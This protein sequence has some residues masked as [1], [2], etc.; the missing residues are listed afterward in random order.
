LLTKVG[1]YALLRVFTLIF[2]FDE[3]ISNLFLFA[4]SSTLITG[5]VGEI[6]KR[7]I[8]RMFSYLIVCHIGFLI[9]GLG[10][11]TMVALTGAIF[12]L[13]HDVII[14]TNLF[15]V[16]GVI[17][18]IKG[19]M[20]MRKLGGMYADYPVLSLVMAVVLFS[21]VG[22]PP[23]SGFWAKIYLFEAGFDTHS[24]ILTTA[25]ILASFITLLVMARMWSEVFWKNTPEA[26]SHF[27]DYFR[28][29][30]R[31]QQSALIGPVV[32]L[33]GVSLYIGF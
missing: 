2:I 28:E 33:M 11:F 26:G 14:K 3:F 29:L 24:Y 21:L 20:D 27:T 23:L 5:A 9:A 13:I 22:I 30:S 17:H 19:S 32:F 4:A 31:L 18:K 8:R 16:A 7:D 12:Y 6:N 25:L 1:V 10:M 15:L